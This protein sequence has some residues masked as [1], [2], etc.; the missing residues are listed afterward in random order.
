[1]TR[2]LFLEFMSEVFGGLKMYYPELEDKR[3]RRFI[4]KRIKT[5]KR[6]A[7]STERESQK[8]YEGLRD[9]VEKVIREFEGPREWFPGTPK[10]SE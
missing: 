3:V 8:F 1:M 2:R 7:P 5:P 6:E 9:Q 10:R 4:L